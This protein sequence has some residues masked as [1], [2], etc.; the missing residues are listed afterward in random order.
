MNDPGKYI[1]LFATL[2]LGFIGFI[3]ALILLFLGIRL[4][5]GFVNELSWFTYVFSVFVLSVPA[6]IFIT[7][8]T[9][10]YFRTRQHPSRGIRIMSTIIFGVFICAWIFFYISD[11]I[12]FFTKAQ[13]QIVDTKSW[14]II[15]VVASIS[16]LF[17]MGIIQALGAPKEPDW[18][19][20]NAKN[21]PV[22]NISAL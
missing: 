8:F 14:N 13:T 6:T 10:F 16:C 21:N 12:A 19:E 1:R 11:M 22:D 5:F 2:I 17:I 18:L 20:R 7:A 4:V 15:Y 9:I 3:I